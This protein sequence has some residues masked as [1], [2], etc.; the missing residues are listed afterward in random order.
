MDQYQRAATEEF[1]ECIEVYPEETPWAVLE[2]R[3]WYHHAQLFYI[4]H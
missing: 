3:Q 2:I 4:Y 1:P